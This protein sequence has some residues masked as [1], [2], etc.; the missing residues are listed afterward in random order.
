MS[1]DT[2]KMILVRDLVDKLRG[3]LVE[4]LVHKKDLTCI[5][6]V[7]PDVC[8]HCHSDEM[9]GIEIM[10]AQK[11]VLLWECSE[12][13]DVYLK[14]DKDKTEEELQDASEYWTNPSDWGYRPHSEFN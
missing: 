4:Q 1:E 5:F 8:P 11:G 6:K 9:R 2:N 7:I 12:C 10:G 13:L 14:Y 3:N